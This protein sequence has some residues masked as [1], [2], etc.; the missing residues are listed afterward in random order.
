VQG[1]SNDPAASD[2]VARIGTGEDEGSSVDVAD[3]YSSLISGNEFSYD[4]TN[5]T[6]TFTYTPDPGDPVLHYLGLFQGGSPAGAP[7]TFHNTY[8]LFYDGGTVG[9]I[10]TWTVNLSDLFINDGLSHIDVFDETGGGTP[11][12]EPATWAMM[13]FGFGATGIAIR[14]SRRKQQLAMTQIA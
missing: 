2:L 1:G 14:R 11:T 9:G 12:P 8:D 3:A 10:T 6:L 7:D 13:L 5:N 4:I